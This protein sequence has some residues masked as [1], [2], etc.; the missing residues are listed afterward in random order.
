MNLNKRTP[1]KYLQQI[2]VA[3]LWLSYPLL[4]AASANTPSSSSDKKATIAIITGGDEY[5]SGEIM[6]PFAKKLED[7]FGFKV[8]LIHDD[9]PGINGDKDHDPKPTILKGAAQIKDADLLIVF[10]RFRNWEP[11]SLKFFMDHFNSGKPALA[12]R[13]TTHGFWKDRTFAP[14]HFG[15]HYKT[16]KHRLTVAQVNPQYLGHP[17]L[18]GVDRKFAEHEGPY[19]STPLTEGAEPLILSYGSREKRTSK[20]NKA[21]DKIIGSDSFD[22]PVAPIVWTF[23]DK[24]A[25]RAMITPMSYRAGTQDSKWAQNIFYNSVFWALSYEVPEGGV[26]SKGKDIRIEKEAKAYLVPQL[27]YPEAPSYSLPQGWTTLFNGQ[28][29]KQWKHYDYLTSKTWSHSY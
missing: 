23:K 27:Q 1:R 8:I 28:D 16:H 5:N 25:R 6:K 12:I 2:L 22:S 3:T 13:T 10:M 11:K 4:S 9:A 20:K 24:G 15:G 14:V 26:L 18:R 7:D 21:F 29:L 19:L 17:I